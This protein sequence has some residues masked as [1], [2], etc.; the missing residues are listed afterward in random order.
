[1]PANDGYRPHLRSVD[2]NPGV[3]VRRVFATIALLATVSTVAALPRA[4]RSEAAAYADTIPHRWELQYGGWDR[5]SSPKLADLDRD[6]RLDIVFGAQDGVVRAVDADGRA[7][8]GW[9][10]AAVVEGGATA[11]DSSPAIGDLD[12]DG[13]LEIAV[14]VGS[15]WVSNQHGGLV[16]FAANGA[17]RCRY[18]TR[19]IHNIWVETGV[20][21]G[22]ADG[23]Y[24]SPAIGDVDGDGFDDIVFGGFDLRVH[25]VDRNCRS[26]PGFPYY[27]NDT[28]WSSPAL[29]DV[30][31]DGRQE[32]FI[33]ADWFA[34]G[35]GDPLSGG[36]F[37]RLDWSGGGV[38]VTWTRAANDVYTS[39]PALGDVDG[40]GRLE[41][42]VGGGDFFH[43][44]DGLRVHAYHLDDGSTVGGWPQATSGVTTSSPAL[45]DLTGD[46][47]PEVVV[48]SR[49][50]QVHA[51]RGNGAALWHRKPVSGGNLTAS[52]LVA[53]LDGD[54]DQDVGV[55]NSFA[56]WLLRGS[57]G[58]SLGSVNQV[59]S[60]ES[61]GAVGDFGAAGRQLVTIGF[62]TPNRR[63]RV[64][65]TPLPDTNA[66]DAWPMF[67]R[68][69]RNLRAVSSDRPARPQC[70]AVA[71]RRSS[72]AR[73]SSAF[74]SG[75]ALDVDGVY[76]HVVAVNVDGDGRCDLAWYAPGATPDLLLRGT[77]GAPTPVGGYAVN[78]SYDAVVAGD[79]DGDGYG[80]LLYYGRGT[81]GDVLRRGSRSG[82]FVSGP[83]I[84]INGSY[85][86]VV[87]GDFDGDGYGDVFLYG[88]GT[89]GDVVRLGGR[90]ASFVSA[91][92][93]A[94]NGSYDAIV[95]GD[96]NGD[97]V[98]DL[99][100]Y[101]RGTKGDVLRL[102]TAFAVFAN[103]PSVRVDGSYAHVVAGD[104]DGDGP[105]DLVYYGAG[106]AG[107]VLRRGSR[108]GAFVSG[109]AIDFDENLA[110]L[111]AGDLD[112]DLRTD[113]VG[114]GLG[115]DPDRVWLGR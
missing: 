37:R 94:V 87:P 115:T 54:G 98:T 86:A 49:D 114:Y 31:R 3:P 76:A 91:S 58:A 10:R 17:T 100:F 12:H 1:M 24:S 47:R 109:P 85:D 35:P 80:D 96:F 69:A 102:G 13:S 104:F 27:A 11:V 73:G 53:D 18:R 22:Y 108:T 9:P 5:S 52:P 83:A 36:R 105:D 51:Y 71:S 70:H 45:G 57:D 101:G 112:G 78:G 40:D 19:D 6:G 59:I 97:R 2:R 113:L 103:G 65:S 16:V 99:F 20:P 44:S 28:V 38:G 75:P 60:F 14:G 89:K 50:G 93:F 82:T 68:N 43:R 32:I 39:S 62:D 66:T 92:P 64:R 33:G 34:Q 7:L 29:Y 48:G 8:A 4:A 67:G 61:S 106:P 107:D 84:A 56:F 110:A 30:D 72:L 21:D 26:L 25:A 23:V 42:V 74:A 111:V 81:K 88:R 63:T 95:P 79:F 41:A 55:G 46:G 90:G 77:A 15:T